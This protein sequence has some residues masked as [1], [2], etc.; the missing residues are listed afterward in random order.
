MA[1][2]DGIDVDPA[3]YCYDPGLPLPRESSLVSR[4]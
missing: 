4:S 3:F 2:D 1:L